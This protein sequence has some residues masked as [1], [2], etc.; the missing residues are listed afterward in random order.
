MY[1]PAASARKGSPSILF[2]GSHQWSN[3]D[4]VRLLPDFFTLWCLLVFLGPYLRSIYYTQDISVVYWMGPWPGFISS[5]AVL[6]IVIGAI[7]HWLTQVPSK[8]AVI[9]SM[10]GAGLS[11]GLTADNIALNSY[12]LRNIFMASDC[13]WSDQK[14][15]LEK[16][17]ESA[18][19]FFVE[20]RSASANRTTSYKV[21]SD[22]PGYSVML[23]KQAKNWNYLAELEETYGCAGWCYP[24]TPI[25]KTGNEI[26]DPCS[27]VV[28]QILT[29]KVIPFA[30][31]VNVFGM[32]VSALTVV[33]LILMGG[34][35]RQIGVGW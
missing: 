29:E 24:S 35:M 28:A 6:F 12:E 8:V 4:V 1:L 33:F 34:T 31:Q 11:L 13:R 30:K 22:C 19:E 3:V 23:T 20:C 9:I 26:Q 18:F 2:V 10:I 5:L 14:Y 21:I 32:V 15:E 7:M 25:W 16:A 27:P 17:W